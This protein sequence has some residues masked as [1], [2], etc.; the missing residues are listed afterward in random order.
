M[1]TFFNCYTFG[2][3]LHLSF[4]DSNNEN[5]NNL[6]RYLQDKGQA[7]LVFKETTPTVE[8]CFI[9][10]LGGEDGNSN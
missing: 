6:K 1:I 5:E 3:Y 8:D 4:K 10:L 7:D 9:R 2:E